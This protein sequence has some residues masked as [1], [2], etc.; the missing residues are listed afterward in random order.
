MII[1][2]LIS[3]L[4][5]SEAMDF[6]PSDVQTL[7][8]LAEVAAQNPQELG[9]VVN[10]QISMHQLEEFSTSRQIVELRLLWDQ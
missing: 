5:H 10:L 2:F 4:S 1:N 6:T 7:T 8:T 3:Q 9:W